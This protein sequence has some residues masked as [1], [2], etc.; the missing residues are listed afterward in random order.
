MET[1]IRSQIISLADDKYKNFMIKLTPGVD[2]ILGVR[3]P[4]LRKIA[5]E[6]LKD[7]WVQYLQS[8]DELYFEEIMVKGMVIGYAKIPFE[9]KKAYI[10][11]FVPKINNWAVCD[12]FCSGLKIAK[13]H[14]GEFWSFLKPYINSNKPYYIRFALVMLLNYFM[15]KDY[16]KDILKIIDKVD[17]P[18]Y[19]VKM[20][21]A[22][23]LSICF[24]KFPE[25]TLIYL[26]G[27]KLDNFTYNKGLQKIIESY[28]VD[29]DT[30]E[31][32][33]GFKRK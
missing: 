30:K 12:S 27:S 5:K 31:I 17:H 7:N 20:A 11:D 13:A 16:I 33:K 29:K 26:K 19:Y 2:N 23:A 15:E 3:T 14:P 6:I 9:E 8:K 22:W 24:V 18:D 32:I 28:R 25:E 1:I 4:F 21:A 10:A